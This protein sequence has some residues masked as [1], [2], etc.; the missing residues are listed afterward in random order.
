MPPL[1]F[2]KKNV[3]ESTST[4]K[5]LPI[6][7]FPSSFSCSS[8]QR[9]IKNIKKNILEQAKDFNLSIEFQKIRNLY[10][11]FDSG[12]MTSTLINLDIEEMTYCLAGVIIKYIELG[13]QLDSLDKENFPFD[14]RNLSMNTD[15]NEEEKAYLDYYMGSNIRNEDEKNFDLS[16]KFSLDQSKLLPLKKEEHRESYREE[17]EEEVE[18]EGEREFEAEEEDIDFEQSRKEI[19]TILKES[20]LIRNN[21]NSKNSIDPRSH[22]VEHFESFNNLP[23]FSGD[24]REDNRNFKQTYDYLEDRDES[25]EE[26]KINPNNV[27]LLS[28][29]TR[30]DESN[31]NELSFSKDH[32]TIFDKAFNEKIIEKW[33]TCKPTKEVIS[34]FC[35]NIIITSKMEKEVTI[36]CLIYLERLILKSKFSLTTINWR[37]VIFISLILA[38]KVFIYL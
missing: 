10:I 6:S 19:E 27:S 31:V 18:E 21:D 26:S 33:V 7:S 37:R 9:L 38:S 29:I 30:M 28:K 8:A 1:N 25:A 3:S 20:L 4:K 22:N 34:N 5:N 36:I 24:M 12:K 32:R 15:L 2:K 13:E 23:V 16:D 14:F 17:E 11:S 35:K